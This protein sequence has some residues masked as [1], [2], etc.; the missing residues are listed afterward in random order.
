MLVCACESDYKQ[1]TIMTIFLII[2]SFL[3]SR[4]LILFFRA[5]LDRNF[6]HNFNLNFL[7][8]PFVESFHFNEF[9]LSLYHFQLILVIIYSLFI[10]INKNDLQFLGLTF[11][12][13]KPSDWSYTGKKGSKI[14]ARITS[15][16][17]KL[18]PKLTPGEIVEL[19]FN[20]LQDSNKFS[21]LDISYYNQPFR[22]LYRSEA[23]LNASVF[24]FYSACMKLV[25]QDLR[26]LY[27]NSDYYSRGLKTLNKEG[28]TYVALPSRYVNVEVVSLAVDGT[29]EHLV[30]DFKLDLKKTTDESAIKARV[31]SILKLDDPKSGF[32]LKKESVIYFY[33]TDC[34]Y[35][36]TKDELKN[37]LKDI[38]K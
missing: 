22:K 18:N 5:L 1:K 16:L 8:I 9:F 27:E 28:S 33:V 32:K 7:S 15:K 2:I 11:L 20:H 29:V 34:T 36:K 31:S 12:K 24:C 26:D 13:G 3:S 17:K 4:S 38:N 23:V 19:L 35:V 30:K 25:L 6:H 14:L 37:M 10:F 21:V